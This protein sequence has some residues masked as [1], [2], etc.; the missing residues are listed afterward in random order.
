MLRSIPK[1]VDTP[2][3]SNRIEVRIKSERL[4]KRRIKENKNWSTLQWGLAAC[5]LQYI[6]TGSSTDEGDL[7]HIDKLGG[8]PVLK[9]DTRF[10]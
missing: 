8:C 3:D 10:F 2:P 5:Q 9:L 7:L 1:G 4:I 6:K